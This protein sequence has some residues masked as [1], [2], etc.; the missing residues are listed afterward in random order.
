MA[1]VADGGGDLEAFTLQS[2]GD[3]ND[4]QHGARTGAG[5]SASSDFL[6]RRH[7]GAVCAELHEFA[8]VAAKNLSLSLSLAER[9]HCGCHSCV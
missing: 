7:D 6:Q 2:A 4:G 3:R 1:Q 8:V 5:F 9:R